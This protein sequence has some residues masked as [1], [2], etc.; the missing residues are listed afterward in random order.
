MMWSQTVVLPLAV[1]PATPIKK[2]I[3]LPKL[4]LD[5]EGE[6]GVP[7]D[8]LET[9][10]PFIDGSVLICRPINLLTSLAAR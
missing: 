6:T 8:T 5:L 3:C 1:P 7:K 2:G 10:E 4:A 9:S